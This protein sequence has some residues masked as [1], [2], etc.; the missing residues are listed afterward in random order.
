MGWRS[1]RMTLDRRA[2]LRNQL[3]ALIRAAAGRDLHI[4][5]P[6]IATVQEFTEAK[7]TL[8]LELDREKNRGGKLPKTVRV[9][10]MIEVPSLVFQLEQLLKEVDFVSIGTNDLS[11]FL[12]AADRGNPTIWNRY[13]ML[14][15][16]LLRVLKYIND[17]CLQQGVP[18][19]VC[20]EIAAR[21]LEAVTLVGLGFQSLS[22][23]P[24]SLGAVKAALRT[25]N[26]QALGVYLNKQLRSS[27]ASLREK[28]RLYAADH[29]IFI[30]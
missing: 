27:A 16:A 18:C 24:A 6:M 25:L 20:G 10:T 8:M 26:R 28:L 7:R 14:S 13:D 30:E 22:M 29:D 9:G 19:S 23:N 11:Q 4:M 3:R 17:M 2:L 5:F 1:I 21:P 12:Y 15:P